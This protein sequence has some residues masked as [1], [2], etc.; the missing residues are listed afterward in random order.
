MEEGHAR[1]KYSNDISEKSNAKQRHAAI[2]QQSL[3][4]VNGIF[5]V[6]HKKINMQT[7]DGIMTTYSSMQGQIDASQISQFNFFTQYK[8]TLFL[9]CCVYSTSSARWQESACCYGHNIEVEV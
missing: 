9:E 6:E 3:A 1:N 2:K 5:L 7:F 8:Q 4:N